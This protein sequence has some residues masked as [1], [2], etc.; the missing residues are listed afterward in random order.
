MVY[1]MDDID[2]A[3]I[4]KVREAIEYDDDGSPA[5]DAIDEDEMINAMRLLLLIIDGG[6]AA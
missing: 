6:H 5:K 2:R 1:E 4:L 3:L